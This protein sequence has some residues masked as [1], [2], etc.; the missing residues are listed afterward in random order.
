MYIQNEVDNK[1]QPQMFLPKKGSVL[2]WQGHTIHRGLNP[3]NTNMPRESIIGH[4]VSGI[5]GKG[6]DQI[7]MFRSYK[8]GFYI[9]HRNQVDDLYYTDEYG[10]SIIKKED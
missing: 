8:N 7:A 1:G 5:K 4:Y 3:V 2:L 6:S 9:K 10:N